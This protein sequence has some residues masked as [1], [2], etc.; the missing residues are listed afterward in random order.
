VE[1][2]IKL[3]REVAI[4]NRRRYG[5]AELG[6]VV[7]KIL[8]KKP[9]LRNRAK[10]VSSLLKKIVEEVNA[11]PEYKVQKS[12]AGDDKEYKL[13][14]KELKLP[15]KHDKVVMR[16]A[17]NPNGPPNIG[18]A[19]G[20]V[21]NYHLS[22]KYDGKFILR[23]DDTDPKLKKPIA[24]AYDWY[25]EDC[26]WLGCPPDK[27]V[28]ASEHMEKYYSIAEKL[29]KDGNAYVCSCGREEFRVLRR[30]GKPCPHRELPPEH[31]IP[32]WKDMLAGIIKEGEAVVRIKTDLQQPDPA[33]RDWVAFRILKASH[34]RVGER[35][36]VWPTLDF[37]SGV[38]DH[39]LGI[40]HI[41]RGKD[42]IDSQRRQEYLY[43]HLGWK[44]PETIYW[45]R[46]KVR[47]YE[48]LSTSAMAKGIAEGKYNGWDDPKLLTLRALKRRG[49]QPK[50]IYNLMLE[51]GFNPN[52]IELSL[53]NLYAHNRKIVD[54][55]AN[56][57]FFITNPVELVV[58]NVEES[59]TISLS[60]HPSHRE[61]GSRIFRLEKRGGE[62]LHLYVAGEDV[63]KLREGEEVRLK[64]LFNINIEEIEKYESKT[65]I[66]A[67]RLK[68]KNLQVKKIHWLPSDEFI[69][70]KVFKP[71]GVE[72]GIVEK[73]C[74]NLKKGEIVQ[75]ERYGFVRFDGIKNAKLIFY[76]AHR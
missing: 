75:F 46:I 32:L 13:G 42:L 5:K 52:D 12:V 72:E 30:E 56:R 70:A 74:R 69:R 55:I 33:L 10:E 48:K 53:E 1:E 6:V 26:K 7:K 39:E 22:K 24:E 8:A 16:F 68:E 57:Y 4:E 9:E 44:Y 45:G 61:R 51:L 76:F 37:E 50:A 41:I 3:G 18:H 35:Y 17:P 40:T 66:K 11:L 15:G 60:L 28:I 62:V 54:P 19:R 25:V 20:I 65:V 23:F 29:L 21:V 31:H 47:G 2:I 14:E 73:N 64:D 27:V 34:P 43:S 58:K 63:E 38:E 59:L 67:R 36:K 71:E 49:I